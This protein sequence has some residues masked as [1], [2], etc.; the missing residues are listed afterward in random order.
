MASSIKLT[1]EDIEQ[2]NENALALFYS[3]VKSKETLKNM[4]RNLKQFLVEACADLLKGEFDER[5]QQ[6]VNLTREDQ[7]KATQIVLAYVRRLK[8]R[9]SLDKADL[10]YLNP[11]TVP[12]KVKPIKKLLEMNGLG[13]GWKRIYSTYPEPNNTHQG[14][15]YTREEI[16]QMLEY[17]K[18]LDTDFIILASSSGGLRVG[19]WDN[20]TWGNIFPIYQVGDDY[21]VELEKDDE[22]GVVCAG[23]IVY[24]GTPD[25]YVALISL[26]SWQKLEEYKKIWTKKMKRHPI[27]SDSLILERFSNPKP[28][29][30]VAVR[31][32]IED[33]LIKSGCR[34]PLTEGKRRHSVPA[35][36]GF[37]RY[38]DKIMMNIQR[39][40]GTLSAL[41]IKERLMGHDG[42]VK[43][44]KNYFWTDVIDLIPEYLEA[45]PDLMISDKHRLQIKLDL[46]KQKSSEFSK[47]KEE[48]D[49]ALMRLRELEA[50]V[51]RIMKYQMEK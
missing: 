5:A 23:M 7:E 28:L 19:A 43:T 15:G 32:R 12:N 45:M 24:K 10:Y 14:R 8:A 25:E 50:K 37:R 38:W 11:S 1:T 26:E 20:Q 29:T 51:E 18:G 31:R 6:F 48:K 47:V 39:K 22:G 33:L 2:R 42:L 34:S 49:E 3:G 36:H 40:R 35:T 44:D 30:G 46:E 13:L 17:S 4:E 41:V 27:D 16:S 9:A 21:K